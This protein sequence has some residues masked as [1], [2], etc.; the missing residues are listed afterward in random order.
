MTIVYSIC[1]CIHTADAEW[2]RY[3]RDAWLVKTKTFTIW[4]FNGNKLPISVMD[5][6]LGL[7]TTIPLVNYLH[8]EQIR[9]P[10]PQFSY[11][12]KRSVVRTKKYNV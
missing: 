4:P 9:L 11:T 3:N 7:N 1:E 12:K 2:C 5:N 8:I 6:F 10:G